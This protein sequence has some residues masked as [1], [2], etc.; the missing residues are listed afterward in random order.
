MRPTASKSRWTKRTTICGSP[1]SSAKCR[2]TASSTLSGRPRA[3]SARNLG[4]S[5]SKATRRRRTSRTRSSAG[6]HFRRRGRWLPITGP[7]PRRFHMS[8]TTMLDAGIPRSVIPAQAGIQCLSPNITGS[9]LSYQNERG[10]RARCAGAAFRF[11]LAALV[12]SAALVATSAHAIMTEIAHDLALGEN[13]AKVQAINALTS[14]GGA[15]ALAVLQALSDGEVQT[16]GEQVLW[17]KD[18][19]ATDLATGKDV[20][21][22]PEA[23]D[24]VVLNNRVRRELATAIAA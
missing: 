12:L 1:C 18:G 13:D 17:I 6:S 23:R 10:R 11:A 3:P 7:R 22:L 20:T 19:K 8:F 2:R 15:D 4:A 16:A 5:S 24:D 21:P 14:T 9:P